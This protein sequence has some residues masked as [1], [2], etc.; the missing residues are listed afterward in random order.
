M[1]NLS[2]EPPNPRREHRSNLKHLKIN[3]GAETILNIYTN[4]LTHTVTEIVPPLML[5]TTELST[6]LYSIS[7]PSGISGPIQVAF[8]LSL[9]VSKSR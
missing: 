7:F 8:P 4:V 5:A 9:L 3:Q 2:L 1:Y 6:Y